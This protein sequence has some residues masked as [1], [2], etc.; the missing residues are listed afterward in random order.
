MVQWLRLRAPNAGGQGSVPGQGTKSHM[1]QLRA[2]EVKEID[3][4]NNKKE[5]RDA[6]PPLANAGWVPTWTDLVSKAAA[7]NHT[8][9]LDS[10]KALAGQP[11]TKASSAVANTLISCSLDNR[12][13][14]GPRD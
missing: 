3:I 12:A 5:P 10:S 8:Q 1:L 2:G 13:T 4:N 11:R 7:T 9:H 14:G 6:G